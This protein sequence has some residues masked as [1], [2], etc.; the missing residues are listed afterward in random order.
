MSLGKVVRKATE[1]F[2]LAY[3]D[4]FGDKERTEFL[5]RTNKRNLRRAVQSLSQEDPL[6]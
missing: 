2:Y 5:K 6:E 1:S 4:E 3:K